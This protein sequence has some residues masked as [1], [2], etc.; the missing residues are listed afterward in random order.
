MIC[1]GVGGCAC[2][3][4]VSGMRLAGSG[5]WTT[6]GVVVP[7]ASVAIVVANGVDDILMSAGVTSRFGG[8]IFG[9][10]VATML[11]CGGDGTM[12]LVGI[13]GALQRRMFGT[14]TG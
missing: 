8:S 2:L 13:A 11:F 9:R 14:I 7:G 5:P 4:A 10:R 3:D 6:T 1:A 12:V